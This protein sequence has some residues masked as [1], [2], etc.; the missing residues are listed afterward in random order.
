[1]MHRQSTLLDFTKAGYNEQAE[2]DSDASTDVS[3]INSDDETSSASVCT[4]EDAGVPAD[5]AQ[6]KEQSLVQPVLNIYKCRVLLSMPVVS[7][8]NYLCRASVYQ[9][10]V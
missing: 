8:S 5:I 7:S 2:D 9:C 1:M 10:G 3:D 6:S 4:V